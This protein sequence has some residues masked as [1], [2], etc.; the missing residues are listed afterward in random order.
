[1]SIQEN[2][3]HITQEIK[4]LESRSL[5][6]EEV[7]LIAVTKNH[8]VEAIQQAVKWGIQNIGENRVQ[9]L[10]SKMEILGDCTNY[11]LIGS[12]QTN[13]VKYIYDK[14]TLIQ[15]LDRMKLAEEI[16]KRASAT[17]T[18]VPCLVQVNIG[19]EKSKEGLALSEVEQFIYDLQEKKHL[20]VKG[21]MTILPN[22]EDEV[23]LRSLFRKMFQLKETIKKEHY[24]NSSMDILSMGMSGDYKIAIEEGS[25]MV[26]IGTKIFGQREY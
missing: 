15:S 3:E 24:T 20:S 19:E 13:K 14:V 18:I 4:E 2:L 23:Y 17:E 9:E 1:M 10:V 26:R 25:N 5:T 22:S 6:G 21:L 8:G 12:L 7:T 11:H 16:E